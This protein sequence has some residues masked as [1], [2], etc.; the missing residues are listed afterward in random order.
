MTDRTQDQ[1]RV[2]W[3]SPLALVYIACMSVMGFVVWPSNEALVQIGLVAVFGLAILCLVPVV[4]VRDSGIV[5]YKVNVLPWSRVVSAKRV[6][7]LGLPYLV[8]ERDKGFPWWMPLYVSGR[9]TLAA[10]LA[11]RAPPGNPITRAL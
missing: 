4:T 5:L 8:L 9:R 10:A 3:R 7:F 1:F 6:S 11:E 2:S